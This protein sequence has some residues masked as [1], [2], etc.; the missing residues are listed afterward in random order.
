MT[1][2]PL[3]SPALAVITVVAEPG[4][5]I[6]FIPPAPIV[7]L[8]VQVLAPVKVVVPAEP[9]DV[10][11]KLLYVSPPPAKVL[12]EA[13]TSVIEI[14]EP[15][16]FKVKLVA[17]DD[18]TA[19]VPVKVQAPV[20]IVIARVNAVKTVELTIGAVT[21]KPLAL[22]VPIWTSRSVEAPVMDRASLRVNV[23]PTE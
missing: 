9:S 13:L 16:E 4:S 8:P 12:A 5:T 18:Q 1:F 19:P 21:L 17:L 7:Q 15:V 3:P 10:M 11:L 14:V 2:A 22:N 20:P 23:E 6:L